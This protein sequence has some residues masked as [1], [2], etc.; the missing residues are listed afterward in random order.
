[1][2]RLGTATQSSL[3]DVSE[4]LE[5]LASG[6]LTKR[7][8]DHHEG[9][10]AQIGKTLNE[11][12]EGLT[13]IMVQISKSGQTIDRSSQDV[14]GAIEDIA[15][16]AENSAASLE[17]TAAAIEELTASVK[18]TSNNAAEV[19][20]KL[21]ATEQEAQSCAKVA[22]ETA[23]AMEGIE[24]SSGEIGQITKVIDDIA[25]Q[26]NLLALN[27]GVEAARAGDAGRGFAVVASEVRALAQRSS[28]AAR[29]INTLI[30]T[31]E[32]QVKSGVE[33]VSTSNA[34]LEKNSGRRPNRCRRCQ[35]D[36]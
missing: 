17:E 4:V 34:A 33:Q 26:T 23:A 27:A 29:E 15:Q 35:L 30:S 36:C 3:S 18:S 6:D 20:S 25:F 31:S 28:D 21:M 5:A 1:M 12:A 32:A 9:I 11:T 10:F 7:M 8:P 14:S 16:K 24:K 13:S 19:K 22:K 2:N